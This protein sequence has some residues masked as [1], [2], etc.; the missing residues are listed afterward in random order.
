[1]LKGDASLPGAQIVTVQTNNSALTGTGQ[2]AQQDAITAIRAMEAR[3]DVLVATTNSLSG[4][5]G[6]D[7][8]HRWQAALR[9]SATTSVTVPLRTGLT[10]A[11]AHRRAIEGTLVLGPG[12]VLALV[13]WRRRL[14][15]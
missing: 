3:R 8:R 9:R 7:G 15:A 11:V 5:I 6:P 4:W 2:M 12:L 1:M 14:A 13:A 10:P